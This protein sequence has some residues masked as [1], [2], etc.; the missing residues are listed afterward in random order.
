MNGTNV[1]LLS[2]HYWMSLSKETRTKLV[3]LFSIPHTGEAVVSYGPTGPTVQTDGY[4]YQDLLSISTEKMQELLGVESTDFYELI[5]EVVVNVD[6]L[7]AGTYH[8]ETP[9][10]AAA[11]DEDIAKHKKKKNV[12]E[13][14]T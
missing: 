13:Q 2:Q 14:E 8:K 10:E 11:I 3:S 12:N 4:T 9:K 1:S 5:G 6:A 7:I